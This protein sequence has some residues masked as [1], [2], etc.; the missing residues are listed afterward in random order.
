MGRSGR[1]QLAKACA[2][3][4]SSSINHCSK[5][6]FNNMIV[7]FTIYSLCRLSHYFRSVD[8][9]FWMMVA[10]AIQIEFNII[11]RAMPHSSVCF[12]HNPAGLIRNY[13]QRS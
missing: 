10:N 4:N 11:C 1:A 8:I 12:L 7:T 3:K 2:P 9:T 13:K 5:S 6:I